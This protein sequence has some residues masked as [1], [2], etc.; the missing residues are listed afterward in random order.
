MKSKP[1]LTLPTHKRW[2]WPVL[3][4]AILVGI[5]LWVWR[6]TSQYAPGGVTNHA[7]EVAKPLEDALT[8]GGAVKRCSYGDPGLGPDNQR[9]WYQSYFETSNSREQAV[10]RINK[11]ATDNGYNL[12][13]ASKSDRGFLGV[14]D[15]YINNWFFDGSKTSPFNDLQSG[16][17]QLAFALENDGAYDLNQLLCKANGPV[18]VKNDAQHTAVRVDVQLPDTRK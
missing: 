7:Q 3:G 11:I 14:D 12:I 9:P 18:V 16:K 10:A 4:L 1:R 8:A 5:G 17:I 15:K 13:H 2:I 6:S